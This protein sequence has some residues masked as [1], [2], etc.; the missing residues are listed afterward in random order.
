VKGVV[1]AEEQEGGVKK[2]MDDGS[3][4]IAKKVITKMLL[5]SL[6]QQIKI[7]ERSDYW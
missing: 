3:S 4:F 5:N 2:F 1:F 6:A 7:K